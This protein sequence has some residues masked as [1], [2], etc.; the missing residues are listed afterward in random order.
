MPKKKEKHIRANIRRQVKIYKKKTLITIYQ[1]WN[2]TKVKTYG[3]RKA[4]F[5]LRTH[6]KRHDGCKGMRINPLTTKH[7]A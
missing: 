6:G 3:K 4:L 7:N 2:S 1:S 5:F